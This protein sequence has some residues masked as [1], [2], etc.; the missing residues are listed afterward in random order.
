MS[1]DFHQNS[2]IRFLLLWLWFIY[3]LLMW[4]TLYIYSWT[5]TM[6]EVPLVVKGLLG[7]FAVGALL[8]IILLPM[9]FSGIEYYQVR[10]QPP[11]PNSPWPRLSP[12][13]LY[14]NIWRWMEMIDTFLFP[15][16]CAWS[17]VIRFWK[18]DLFCVWSFSKWWIKYKMNDMTYYR[19]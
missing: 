1:T 18:M 10:N 5:L 2:Y 12:L 3:N 17:V 11:P 13:F 8:L 4:C 6:G 15:P 7:L 14:V 16:E 9:S 19:H